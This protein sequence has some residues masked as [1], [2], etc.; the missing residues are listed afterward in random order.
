MLLTNWLGFLHVGLRINHPFKHEFSRHPGEA[1]P[2]HTGQR[3][4]WSNPYQRYLFPP[5]LPPHSPRQRD[6]QVQQFG[7][8]QRLA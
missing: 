8:R 7:R 6:R 2:G 5:Q 3:P 4:T 1:S